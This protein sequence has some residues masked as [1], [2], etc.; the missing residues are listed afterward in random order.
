MNSQDKKNVGGGWPSMNSVTTTPPDAL[1]S[2]TL[3]VALIGPAEAGRKAITA[4][5][6]TVPSTAAREFSTYPEMDDVSRLLEAE[7]DVIIIELD[8][9]PEY[10]LELVENICGNSSVTVMVYSS[11]MNQ[12]L[13]VR[14]MRAGAREFLTYPITNTTIAE[15]MVRAAVRRPT[16]RVAKKGLGKL[17]VFA[18]AK[19]GSGVTTIASN[20]AI[21]LAK[22]SGQSVALVDLNLPL[23]NAALDLGLTPEYSTVNALQNYTRLDSN[24]LSTLFTKHSSG[25]SVLAAP[26]KYVPSQVTDEAVER[27]L[28]VTR[29]EFDYVVVDAGC[30]YDAISR[31]LFE[32]S[33]TV[34]LVLQVS[35][36]ELRNANR[37]ISDLFRTSNVKVEVVLN[38]FTPRA[39]SIDEASITKALTMP[40]TWRVPGDYPAA[41]TAQ[42]TATPI[43]LEDSPISRVIRQMTKAA[44]GSNDVPEKKKRF[45]LFK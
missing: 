21:S 36:S 20:F 32:N 31:A 44:S 43:V 5:L 16:S 15:A 35:I 39:L 25:L 2:A 29:Q 26:D 9:N 10:A 40:P 30:R 23:G 45:N 37:L 27:L 22:E 17:L 42:N 33:T 18:G 14:C 12:E 13:L 34:Y 28:L 7:Y 24:F 6:S 8:S 4:A 11:R 19:G 41:R 3:A 1:G 38:R